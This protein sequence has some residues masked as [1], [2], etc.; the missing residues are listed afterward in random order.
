MRQAIGDV[1]QAGA[2]DLGLFFQSG[3]MRGRFGGDGNLYV[4]GLRGWQTA[5]R[6]DGCLQRVRYT[7][8]P[9]T[10]PI[11]LVARRDGLELRFESPLDRTAAAD[12]T[13]YKVERWNYRWS[14]E[15]GSKNWSVV[16]PNREGKDPVIVETVEIAA[17]G[18]SVFLR[19]HG[20]VQPVMQMQ[21]DYRLKA[22]DGRPLRGAVYNTVHATN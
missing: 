8:K 1:Q 19:L 15:Y 13:R 20:G 14:G 18:R 6:R 5:A 9:L 3:A 17:D 2:V 12:T 11:G 7:G 22:A 21:V 10:T 4:C 16:D